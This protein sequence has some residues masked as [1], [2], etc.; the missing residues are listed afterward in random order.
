MPA[1]NRWNLNPNQKAKSNDLEIKLKTIWFNSLVFLR[2]SKILFPTEQR[3][4]K[5]GSLVNVS[6][7]LFP[8]SVLGVVWRINSNQ[9][10][11]YPLQALN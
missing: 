6:T 4:F 8:N 10:E 11:I 9:M 7:K 3:V 2:H 5:K 1:W